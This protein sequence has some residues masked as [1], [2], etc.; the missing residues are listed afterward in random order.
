MK[1]SRSILLESLSVQPGDD[2]LVSVTVQ[3]PPE[4]VTQYCRFLDSLSDF[5]AAVDRKSYLVN[6]TSPEVQR[7]RQQAADSRRAA[8]RA[9]LVLL[10]DDY[11]S[12]GLTR[13]EA[14]RRV[15]S[16]LRAEHHPWSAA[17]LVR[18]ELIAAGRPG[19]PGRPRRSEG[20]S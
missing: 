3:L 11:K 14:I 12:A 6:L 4:L 7:D 1:A 13:Q 18:S 5:F 16:D 10:F 2:G 17:D 9:R 15:S 8:F 19:V 20:K